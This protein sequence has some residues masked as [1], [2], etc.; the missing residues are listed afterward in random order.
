M[1]YS[2]KLKEYI[3]LEDENDEFGLKSLHPKSLKEVQ[4]DK[5]FSL[6]EEQTKDSQ[7]KIGDRILQDS[8]KNN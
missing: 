5:L 1:D 2:E 4:L 8:R 6:A 3:E 7:I